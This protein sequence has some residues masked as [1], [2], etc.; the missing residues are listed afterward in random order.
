MAVQT[1]RL[2]T[3]EE[4]IGDV[5]KI[6]NNETYVLIPVALIECEEEGSITLGPWLYSN[7]TTQP[8]VIE[9]EKIFVTAP[10]NDAFKKSYKVYV[11]T[12][13]SAIEEYEKNKELDFDSEEFDITLH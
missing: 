4:I 8:I 1:L 3:G 12:L 13:A 6:E 7:D 2:I 9:N 11:D 5:V 10:T